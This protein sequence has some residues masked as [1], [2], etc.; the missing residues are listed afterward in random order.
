MEY[1]CTY[2][3]QYVSF[4]MLHAYNMLI[5]MIYVTNKIVMLICRNVL[6]PNVHHKVYLC[7]IFSDINSN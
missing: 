6:D 4:E 3:R 7:E 2:F 5:C 1:S